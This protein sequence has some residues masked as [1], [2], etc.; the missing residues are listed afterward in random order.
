M[1]KQLTVGQLR[2]AI[3]G[4]PNDSLVWVRCN[5]EDAWDEKEDVEAT[6]VVSSLS[7]SKLI[8]ST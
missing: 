3:K 6:V 1:D 2:E 7:E 4:L 8:I 5:K